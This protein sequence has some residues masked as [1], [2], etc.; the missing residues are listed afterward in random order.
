MP[1]KGKCVKCSNDLHECESIDVKELSCK[2][3]C[4]SVCLVL[5]HEEG[6]EAYCSCRCR[7]PRDWLKKTVDEIIVRSAQFGIYY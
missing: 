2:H 6:E 5:I 7:I 4:H 1:H 3:Y